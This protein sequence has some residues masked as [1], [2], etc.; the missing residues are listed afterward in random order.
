MKS[1]ILI[2]VLFVLLP[3]A[4]AARS[5]DRVQIGRSIIVEPG[6]QVGD[7][8]CIACSIRVRG[9][10]AGDTVAVAGSITLENGAQIAGDA[11]AVAGSVR[12][13]SDTKVGGDVVAVAGKIHR[14]P[15]AVIGG[16]VTSVGGVGWMWPILLAPFLVLGGIVALIIWLVQRKR[17][18]AVAGGYPVATPNTRL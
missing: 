5:N 18:T 13:A 17:Q 12:L 14:D 9:Q 6:E 10:I 16:D 4:A 8:V 2:A 1:V 11:V 15:Q 7:V 3:T